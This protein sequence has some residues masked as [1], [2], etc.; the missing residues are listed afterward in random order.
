MK[1]LL[2]KEIKFQITTHTVQV[3]HFSSHISLDKQLGSWPEDDQT[4]L[5]TSSTN[6]KMIQS[7]AGTSLKRNFPNIYS[8]VKAVN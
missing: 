2:L 5:W 4:G 6:Y 7:K 3:I 1:E 8:H